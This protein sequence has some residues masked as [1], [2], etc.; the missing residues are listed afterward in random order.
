[1]SFSKKTVK[2]AV[3]KKCTFHL[4]KRTAFCLLFTVFFS[5]FAFSI[6]PA[7]QVFLRRINMLQSD[8]NNPVVVKKYMQNMSLDEKIAQ[9]FLLNLEGNSFFTEK[10]EYNDGISPGGYLLFSYNVADSTDK[11]KTF[12]K[13]INDF[14]VKNN[15]IPPFL[16]I[17]HEGGYVNR[18]RKI[19][20]KFPSQEEVAQNFSSEQAF[21]EYFEQG[22]I[23]KDLGIHI[24]LAP[25]VEEK[26]VDNQDFL[27]NRSFGSIENVV[28]YGNSCVSAYIKS[29]IIPVLKHFPGNTNDDPHLGL[30]KIHANMQDFEKMILPFKKILKSNSYGYNCAVLLSHA[31]LPQVFGEIPAC[32]SKEMVTD[33]LKNKMNFTGLIISDDIYMGALAKNGYSPEKAAELS[34]LSGVDLIML[35][36]KKF[37]NLLPSLKNLYLSNNEFSQRIDESCA[38]V[39]SAKLQ[40]KL[41]KVEK[42]ENSYS[43]MFLTQ[44]FPELFNYELSF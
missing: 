23:L 44:G 8:V 7:T 13:S 38:K 33:I 22:K 36:P 24:N 27:D 14:Y 4:S 11:I 21:D 19:Y 12:T 1:M 5:T 40:H 28:S 30:P 41:I 15:Q 9:L 10:T 25:I 2:K 16:A 37:V 29:G 42:S 31:M 17:D 35:S 18:L 32:F 26:T 6:S 39:L 3:L 43:Q 34:I 20:G